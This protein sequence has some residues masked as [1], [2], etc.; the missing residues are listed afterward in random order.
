MLHRRHL[1][2]TKNGMKYPSAQCFGSSAKYTAYT[3]AA[4]AA[5]ASASG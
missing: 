4:A 3:A 2:I 5:A 1:K